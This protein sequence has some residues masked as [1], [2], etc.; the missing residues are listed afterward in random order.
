M[1]KDKSGNINDTSLTTPNDEFW[2]RNIQIIALSKISYAS[3][4]KSSTDGWKVVNGSS[5]YHGPDDTM[6][7]TQNASHRVTATSHYLYKP[8]L[9][10]IGKTYTI[11]GEIYIDPEAQNIT[12]V[13]VAIDNLPGVYPILA[14]T[15]SKGEYEKF[16]IDVIPPGPSGDLY[17][18]ASN[19][20]EGTDEGAIEGQTYLAEGD[21][22]F[23]IRNFKVVEKFTHDTISSGSW[24]DGRE[25]PEKKYSH[26]S[27]IVHE[28]TRH[29]VPITVKKDDLVTIWMVSATKQGVP[30]I[31]TTVNPVSG[32]TMSVK[33]IVLARSSD[34]SPEFVPTEL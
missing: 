34:I 12:Q 26:I 25:I 3:N 11:S 18:M 24:E 31:A 16:S 30:V 22:K 14:T 2:A 4:F 7:L 13:N 5:G 32:Q 6:W 27:P 21:D 33:N 20:P 1:W 10:N 23:F 28:W 29:S 19:N 17:L 8:D 9:L 15:T